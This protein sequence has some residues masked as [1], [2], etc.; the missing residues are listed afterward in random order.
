M[1]DQI[2]LCTLDEFKTRTKGDDTVSLDD[3]VIKQ[4]IPSVSADIEEHL[5]RQIHLTTTTEYFDVKQDSQTAWLL[6]A[7]PVTGITSVHF[8]PDWAW[9]S[10]TEISSS[11]YRERGAAG[12]LDIDPGL[13]YAAPQALKVVYMGGIVANA[14]A[15]LTS[16]VG[17]ILKEAAMMQIAYLV[18]TRGM[19]GAT[20]AS[21]GGAGSVGWVT[22]EDLLPEVAKKLKRFV[23]K[24]RG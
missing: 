24:G 1:A 21:G 9:G 6:R 3:D 12:I 11:Y 15:L 22:G 16:N 20:D 10:A 18:N 5:G 19:I 13:T 4:L 7:Y 23:N 17:L 8:D 14:A 2:Q